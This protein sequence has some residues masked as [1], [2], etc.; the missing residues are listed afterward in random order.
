MGPAAMSFFVFGL[1]MTVLGIALVLAPN[2]LLGLVG[3]A[4]TTDVWVRVVGVLV[5]VIGVLDILVGRADLRIVM[6]WGI[7][8]R[9]GAAA[10]LVAF[11]VA[12]LVEPGILIFAAVDALSVAW[13][14]FALRAETPSRQER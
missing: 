13:T 5:V 7:Y 8:L 1:Y 11:W 14:V 10:S 3:I 2:P 4:E 9:S 12:D 6:R